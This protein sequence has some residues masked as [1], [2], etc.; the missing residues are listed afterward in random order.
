M[1]TTYRYLSP[2]AAVIP[3]WIF[4]TLIALFVLQGG[5][6][7]G[8][9]LTGVVTSRR[10]LPLA[11]VKVIIRD[12]NGKVVST[13]TTDKNGQYRAPGLKPATYTY[14]LDGAR[15]GFT[16]GSPT[17]AHLPPQGLNIDWT[18]TS[19][20]TLASASAGSSQFQM[21]SDSVSNFFSGM[22]GPVGTGKSTTTNS[23]TASSTDPTSSASSPPTSGPN[24]PGVPG[25]PSGWVGGV[26]VGAVIV[27]VTNRVNNPTPTPPPVS[28][29]Q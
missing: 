13:A 12:S 19:N 11:N 10:G 17:I 15:V 28:P 22:T 24:G 18:M 23:D 21:G 27:P 16:G 2:D 3:V 7:S 5:A 26:P 14:T 8:A 20:A 25:G 9:E 6:A 29:T 4:T 1:R